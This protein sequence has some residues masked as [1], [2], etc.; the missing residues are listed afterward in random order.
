MRHFRQFVTGIF[1]AF[2]VTLLVNVALAEAANWPSFHGPNRDR[3]CTE[4]GLLQEWPEGG[5]KLL[6]R[7]VD[8]GTGYGGPTIVAEVLYIMGDTD[9]QEWVFALDA[10]QQG[11]VIWATAIGPVQY[12]DYSPGTRATPTFDEGRIYALGASGALVCLDAESGRIVFR[13]SLVSDFGGAM[14]R[15]GYAE[16]LLID[17][18]LLLCTPGGKR[19][20]MAALNKKDGKTVWVSPG[21]DS[22]NY[23][24]IVKATIGGV[25]QYVQ[26]VS[27]AVIGVDAKSGKQLW[28][29]EAPAYTEYGGINIATPIVFGDT[30]FAASGYGVGGGLADIR[31]TADGFSAKERYFTKKMKNH[32]GGIILLDG[33]LYGCN[34]PGILTCLEYAT[35]QVA[36]E[37]RKPGKCSVLFADGMLYCR[38]ETGPI[39]LVEATPDAFRIR[40]QFEQPDRSDQKSWPHLVIANGRLYVRDQN[41]L[42]V[43]DVRANP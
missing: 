31:R 26:F 29:Y 17:G 37:S 16:S 18:E 15:W 4:T 8:V 7:S 36:W 1:T 3:I 32:H 5:P 22:A 28:R 10:A 42:L 41:L 23:S 34:D 6:Y 2:V 13:K 30:V 35:G 38:S 14:P 40:G 24:S 21:G 33:Y 11:K 27:H 43:Y 12:N 9:E 20:T 19:A 25:A 39:S